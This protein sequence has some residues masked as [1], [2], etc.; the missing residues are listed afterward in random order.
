M[1]SLCGGVS[2][3][4]LDGLVDLWAGHE[5]QARD[6][7]KAARSRRLQVRESGRPPSARS[8]RVP[9][10]PWSLSSSLPRTVLPVSALNQ[11]NAARHRKSFHT[12]QLVDSLAPMALA[13][14]GPPAALA[15]ADDAGLRAA[16][17]GSEI[18]VKPARCRV[19]TRDPQSQQAYIDR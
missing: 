12:V 19:Q 1:P 3:G 18:P 9:L 14:D 17:G 10:R 13:V 8:P 5:P 15:R 2:H 16:E 11:F 6:P 7:D 4:G